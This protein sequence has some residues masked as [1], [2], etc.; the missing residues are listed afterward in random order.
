M[1]QAPNLTATLPSLFWP[2]VSPSQG[3]GDTGSSLRGAG[4]EVCVSPVPSIPHVTQP[5]G[6]LQTLWG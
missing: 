3:W 1:A 2:P 6:L 5:T 4:A